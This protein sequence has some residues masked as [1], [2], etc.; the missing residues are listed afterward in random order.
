MAKIICQ[1]LISSK[2]TPRSHI[3][4]TVRDSSKIHKVEQE[5]RITA[6]TLETL[7]SRSDLIL[8]CVRPGQA[9]DI[10]TALAP[11]KLE[12]KGFISILAGVKISYFEKFLDKC[13]LIRA[14]PNIASE[15]GEGMTILTF[16]L[17]ASAEMK[18]LINL[19]FS[20]MGRTIE[21]PETL[22][23]IATAI[24]GSGPAFVFS[25]IE[26]VARLGEKEGIAYEQSIQMAAQTF[27]GAARIILQGGASVE[28]LL[29]QIALPNGTTEAGIKVIKAL[30]IE[31]HF[32][33][34]IQAAASRSKAISQE[35]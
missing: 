21:L 16:G 20:S 24:A 7:V 35:I 8:L 31:K 17:D 19:L 32:Q 12:G 29:G 30:E 33:S 14:M 1:S 25:L 6:T 3:F 23:D 5:F 28:D 27:L 9:G 2:L 11:F 22:M 26:A 13:T 34:V 15:V 18:S 10:L 4:F